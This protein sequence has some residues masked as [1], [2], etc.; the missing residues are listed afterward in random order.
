MAR[1]QLNKQELQVQNENKL[2]KG[3]Q[4][5]FR[6]DVSKVYNDEFSIIRE[7]ASTE[8]LLYDLDYS[9]SYVGEMYP[10]EFCTCIVCDVLTFKLLN[11]KTLWVYEPY[12]NQYILFYRYDEYDVKHLRENLHSNKIRAN[13]TWTITFTKTTLPKFCP[14]WSEY[15]ITNLP[16][17]SSNDMEYILLVDEKLCCYDGYY[18]QINKLSDKYR[19][20]EAIC[21]IMAKSV[22]PINARVVLEKVLQVMSHSSAIIDNSNLEQPYCYDFKAFCK[23]LSFTGRKAKK[24]DIVLSSL[25]ELTKIGI[26]DSFC[27]DNDDDLV[28]SSRLMTKHIRQQIKRNMGYYAQIPG[29]KQAPFISVFIDYLWWIIN[30]PACYDKITISL[31]TLFCRHL[32]LSRLLLEHRNGEIAKILTLLRKVG[33]DYGLLEEPAQNTQDITGVDVKYLLVH[34]TALHEFLQIAPTNKGKE[35]T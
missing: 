33:Q 3:R 24:K 31:E 29:T 17:L 21:G 5:G 7:N 23:D 20:P 35:S 26:I 25:D 8:Q 27:I 13:E 10:K 30:C 22:I 14:R 16:P 11:P 34:R 1:K 19:I 2:N 4:P 18:F 15:K 9:S 6:Y 12:Y 28:F 32:G